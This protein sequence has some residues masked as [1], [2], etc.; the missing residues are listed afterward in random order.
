MKRLFMLFGLLVAI[1]LVKG[2]EYAFEV[3]VTGSGTPILMI[4]GLSSSGDVWDQSVEELKENYE[5][6]VVTLPGFAGQPAIKEENYLMTV[7]DELIKYLKKE[8]LR[9]P[10]IMGHSLGGFL[11]L[12]IGSREPM[13]ASKLIIVD[14]LP[15]FGA[16]QNPSATP[17]TMKEMAAMMKT[18]IAMQTPE[19]YE[20]MQPMMLKT[21]MKSDSDIEIV[22]EWGRKSD[23]PTV[24]Q[25]MY[26]LYQIDLR[27]DISKIETPTLV[28]GAW[29]GYKDFGVTREMTLRSFKLQ[30]KNL[31]NAQ[32]EMTDEG[33]HF[34]MW[35]DPQF[36][37]TKVKG[38]LN[39]KS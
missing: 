29:I 2:Q 7:G 11:S 13:I 30:Y 5:C 23:T 10:V 39:E 6:H 36:F 22:M 34:I 8:K 25:A 12:Y 33:K 16:Q 4:P 15:F 27:E 37:H 1:Y 35:D 28:L 32:I 14:A 18:N 38:F 26:E 19:Q 9:N 17:E 21:M 20:A 31:K 24:A 3:E